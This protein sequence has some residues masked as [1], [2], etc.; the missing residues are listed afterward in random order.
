MVVF[1]HT[2]NMLRFLHLHM[3]AGY[4]FYVSPNT[5]R[6]VS[7]LKL[8]IVNENNYQKEASCPIRGARSPLVWGNKPPGGVLPPMHNNKKNVEKHTYM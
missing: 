2:D 6:Y 1:K 4:P 8:S 3:I 5:L 7:A